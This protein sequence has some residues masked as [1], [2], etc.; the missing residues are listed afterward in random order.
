MKTTASECPE[1]RVTRIEDAGGREY[2]PR[3]VSGPDAFR[4]LVNLA[5]VSRA[6]LNDGTA[7]M[8]YM[9]WKELQYRC[10]MADEFIEEAAVGV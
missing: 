1:H 9:I 2:C 10:D 7:E 4:L 6:V 3:C 5:T 8:P